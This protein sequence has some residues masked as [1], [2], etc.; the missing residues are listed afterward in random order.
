MKSDPDMIDE[1][2]DFQN[3]SGLEINLVEIND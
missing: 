3:E 1:V 2:E